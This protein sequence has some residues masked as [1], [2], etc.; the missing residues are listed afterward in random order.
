MN[1]MRKCLATLVTACLFFA[2]CKKKFDEYYARPENL[3][4]P[5]YQQLQ[6][7]GNFKN[8]IACIDKAGYKESLNG[9]GYWTFFA[10]NDS[11]FQQ[12]FTQRGVSGIGQLDS[13]TC[14]QIVTF[15]LVYNSF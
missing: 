10:P 5:I 7:R 2:G 4:P 6:A 11:A 15:S 9:A 1:H 3:A 14:K 12:F 8:L 13:G